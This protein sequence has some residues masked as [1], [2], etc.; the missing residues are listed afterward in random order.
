MKDDPENYEIIENDIAQLLTEWDSV[1]KIFIVNVRSIR[2]QPRLR[3]R[4]G[5]CCLSV[6]RIEG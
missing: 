1:S 4:A 2:F 6:V 3:L 5:A